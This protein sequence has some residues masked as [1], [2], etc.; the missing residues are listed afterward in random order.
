M[1]SEVATKEPSHNQKIILQELLT[2]GWTS[3]ERLTDQI[4]GDDP[5][6]GPLHTKTIVRVQIHR[7]NK[8]MPRGLKIRSE[9]HGKGVDRVIYRLEP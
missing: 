1:I 6:G 9:R 4:W 8:R 5:D 7:L 2:M 3:R